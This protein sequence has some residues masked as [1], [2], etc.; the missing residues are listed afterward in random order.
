MRSRLTPLLLLTL[1]LVAVA[2]AHSQDQPEVSSAS[3]DMDFGENGSAI[4]SLKATAPDSPDF[5]KAFLAMIGN[6]A[7]NFQSVPDYVDGGLDTHAVRYWAECDAWNR[8]N[9]IVR[10]SIDVRPLIPY[11]RADGFR[12]ILLQTIAPVTPFVHFPGTAVSFGQAHSSIVEYHDTIPL[13]G[14]RTSIAFAFG[15]RAAD[16][17]GEFWPLPVVVAAP[18]LITLWMRRR[19]LHAAQAPANRPAVLFGFSR[20]LE[21]LPLAMWIVWLQ[22]LLVH[23]VSTILDLLI[24]AN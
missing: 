10:G 8:N 4:V 22:L 20:Y 13:D 1:L 2:P 7:R 21:N 14:S 23:Q 18:L 3:L 19:A 5:R 12:T 16:V 6:R 11:L 17:V 9:G 15:Y 24:P